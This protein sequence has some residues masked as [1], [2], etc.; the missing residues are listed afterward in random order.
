VQVISPEWPAREPAPIL[1]FAGVIPCTGPGGYHLDKNHIGPSPGP[2]HL[3]AVAVQTI[4]PRRPARGIQS[5]I[6]P[7]PSIIL[8]PRPRWLYACGV[9]GLAQAERPRPRQISPGDEA[10]GEL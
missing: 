2:P 3:W 9:S 4:S 8:H 6:I 1:F 5:S 7:S 10:G